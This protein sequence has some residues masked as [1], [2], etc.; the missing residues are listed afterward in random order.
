LASV[1]GTNS[2]G[3]SNTSELAI[4]VK[5]LAKAAGTIAGPLSVCHGSTGITFSVSPV[6][7]ATRYTWNI[8]GGATI[9]SG[10]ETNTI[11]V[12]FNMSAL[13]GPITVF[14][15]NSCGNGPVSPDFSLMVYPIPP[16]PQ[17]TVSGITM[18]SSGLQG[19]QWYFSTSENGI[20]S[21]VDGGTN[22]ICTPAQTGWYWTQVT[23]NG[24]SSNL[25]NRVFRLKPGEANRYN[26]YPVP[27][28]GEFTMAITTA[29]E[30]EFSIF[31][32]N[33]AGQKKYEKNGLHINGE[34]REYINLSSPASGIYTVVIKSKDGNVVKKII[35]NR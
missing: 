1:F 4:T 9:V 23:L 10:A 15:S 34:F 33:Q 3:V 28:K 27:N 31:V 13:S 21:M 22:Q 5:P 16:T 14:G 30:K 25:S 11:V 29:D 24:C 2:C 12:D 18:I 17:V 32:Y 8:P 6:A 26:L 7:N 20:G 35:V 19:N